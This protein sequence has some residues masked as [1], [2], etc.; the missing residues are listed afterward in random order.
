MRRHFALRHPFD[1][2]VPDGEVFCG[3][4]ESCGMQTT[5]RAWNMGHAQSATCREMAARR[6]QHFNRAKA[7]RAQR[8]EFVINGDTLRQA[9][10]FKYLGRWLGQ[11]DLDSH[12]VRAQL[13]K[14]HEV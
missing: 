13:I 1:E 2:V 3:K 7:A 6:V 4:C 12:A 8:R 10:S 9:E 11:D 5:P 14:A